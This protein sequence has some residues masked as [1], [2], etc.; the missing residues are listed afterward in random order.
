[1]DDPK[2]YAINNDQ[3]DSIR[4]KVSIC[5]LDLTLHFGNDTCV[6]PEFKGEINVNSIGI[7][8]YMFHS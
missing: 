3:W 8:A 6:L 7:N 1:M 4:N 2:L 5:S